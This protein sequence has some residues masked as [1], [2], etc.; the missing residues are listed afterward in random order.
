[1]LYIWNTKSSKKIYI[2][3]ILKD[4]F[5]TNKK[6]RDFQSLC[7]R[8]IALRI[9]HIKIK[10][11]FSSPKLR[12]YEYWATILI[13]IEIVWWQNNCAIIHSWEALVYKRE[14]W[15]VQKR[16]WKNGQLA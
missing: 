13:N 8:F 9:Y 15:F 14:V 5:I 7:T 4:F 2:N 1:M 11:S 16:Y 6:Y 3:W 12:S 10:G